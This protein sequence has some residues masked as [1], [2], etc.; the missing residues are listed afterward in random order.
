[1]HAERDLSEVWSLLREQEPVAWHPTADGG[2]WVVSRYETA[3]RVYRDTETYTSSRGNVLA[4]LLNGGDPAGGKMLPVSDGPR[5]M[6]IRRELLRALTPRALA[7]LGERIHDATRRLVVEA[8]AR[9]D[10]DLGRDVAPYVPL[11]AICDLLMVPEE[12]RE[13]L[14]SQSKLALASETPDGTEMEARL[15]RNEILLYFSRLARSRQDAPG[16]DILGLLI[17]MTRS[18]VALTDQELLY[19]AYSLLL[20]GDETTRLSMIGTVHALIHR[21]DE[22]ARLKTGEVPIATAVEEFLRWTTPTLHA[23]RVATTDT[24]L[25]GREIAQGD[26]VTIWNSS[27]NF[28]PAQFDDPGRLRL[29]RSP[30]RHLTFAQGPHFCLGAQLARIEL[31]ALVTA[32]V[33][34]ADGMELI[35]E[36]KR[37]YS[38]FLSGFHSLP[39]R[40]AAAAAK[41]EF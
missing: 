20:G 32:L 9:E 39:V 13:L 30:N 17:Q 22:W 10:C 12:D 25:D 41:K 6:Q 26:I 19:N 4:T 33:E 37:L 14:L 5:H 11:A 35:G 18:S 3:V 2:F 29:S 8:V 23:G 24:T 7:G 31:T 1:M 36:P 21:P 38:N 34:A 15:A 27:A 40:F 16:D 28:D